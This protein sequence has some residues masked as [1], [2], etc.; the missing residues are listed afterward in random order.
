MPDYTWAYLI[1]GAEVK[2]GVFSSGLPTAQELAD[3]WMEHINPVVGG[4]PVGEVRFWGGD[5][6]D[7]EPDGLAVRGAR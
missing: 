4:V 1:D 5:D 6:T 7:R 3:Q 2:R